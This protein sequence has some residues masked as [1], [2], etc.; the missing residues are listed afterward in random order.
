[1]I[2]VS[3]LACTRCHQCEFP[4][5][6]ARRLWIREASSCLS[7]RQWIFWLPEW[8]APP[9]WRA[10]AHTHTQDHKQ[11]KQQPLDWCP[12]MSWDVLGPG[13]WVCMGMYSH[14]FSHIFVRFIPLSAGHKIFRRRAGKQPPKAS[15]QPWKP[16]KCFRRLSCPEVYT[17]YS[18]YSVIYTC[19]IM[20]TICRISVELCRYLMIIVTWRKLLIFFLQ[21]LHPT[22]PQSWTYLRL[23]VPKQLSML[24]ARILRALY[25]TGIHWR[26]WKH[27]NKALSPISHVLWLVLFLPGRPEK[28]LLMRPQEL[29]V[30][31]V[32]FI[33]WFCFS[34]LFITNFTSGANEHWFDGTHV[35][36]CL[37]CI[38][39]CC[40]G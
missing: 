31:I 37:W 39:F 25:D 7:G 9:S 28:V 4:W 23:L 17:V 15:T 29:L 13:S 35:C 10:S 33:R 24:M 36:V 34:Y 26:C 8:C 30:E 2:S 5:H 38:G 27:S 18:V 19:R 21:V 14:A 1:M 40:I 12:G 20:Q 16:N 6:L 3:L 22:V 32:E 11:M